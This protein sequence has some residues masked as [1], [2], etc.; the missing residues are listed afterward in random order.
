MEVG[1]PFTALTRYFNVVTGFGTL[2]REAF[3]GQILVDFALH[4]L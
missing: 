1:D 4:R 3:V 2:H